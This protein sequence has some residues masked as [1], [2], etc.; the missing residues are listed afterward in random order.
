LKSLVIDGYNND[1]FKVAVDLNLIRNIEF[2][3]EKLEIRI[4]LPFYEGFYEFLKT[5][6]SVKELHLCLE[7]ADYRYYS[8][9]FREFKNLRKLYLEICTLE[10]IEHEKLFLE[11]FKIES[12]EELTIEQDAKDPSVF[13][14]L[15]EIFPNVKKLKL[16]NLMDFHCSCL[17]SLMKLETL[18]IHLLRFEC[19]FLAKLPSLKSIWIEYLIPFACPEIWQLF[20]LSNPGIENLV[21]NSGGQYLSNDH[22]KFEVSAIVRS[23]KHFKRLQQF[24]LCIVVDGVRFDVDQQEQFAFQ[25]LIRISL[26]NDKADVSKITVSRYFVNECVEDFFFLINLFPN[27][28][29]NYL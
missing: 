17:G 25:T 21:I 10:E 27:T 1:V 28:E 14:K 4:A 16:G 26:E 3:L 9:I 7:V 11:D 29:I 22:A 24:S 18:E 6:T 8:L 19:I 23:L 5:Q 13:S 20:A 15:I 12:L 2:K